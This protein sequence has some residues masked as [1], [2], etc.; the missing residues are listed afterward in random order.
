MSLETARTH[1][2]RYVMGASVPASAGSAVNTA[3]IPSAAQRTEAARMSKT[4]LFRT[5]K[6][7]VRVICSGDA[8]IDLKKLGDHFC[9]GSAVLEPEEALGQAGE[10]EGRTDPSC[11]QVYLD[12]S[13]LRFDTVFQ[14]TEDGGAVE[15]TLEELFKR[16]RAKGWVDICDTPD[17]APVK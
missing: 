11:A 9:F 10:E 8:K 13:M 6:G 16:V 4:L 1:F 14:P 7:S 5:E 15:L 3:P 2:L 12:E 17:A